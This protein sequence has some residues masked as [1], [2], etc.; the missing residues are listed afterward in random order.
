[1]SYT[2]GPL[3]AAAFTY[4]RHAGGFHEPERVGAYT[5]DQIIAY[6][7]AEVARA[8]A[9]ERERLLSEAKRYADHEASAAAHHSGSWHA[10]FEHHLERHAAMRDVIQH[11]ERSSQTPQADPQRL[12][13]KGE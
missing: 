1:M 4:E 12:Q 3:P 2:P 9:A 13:G 8:V 11:M 6:T 5:A 10:A 7:A